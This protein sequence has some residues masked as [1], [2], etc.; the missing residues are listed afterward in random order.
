M[1]GL[2]QIIDEAKK[3]GHDVRIRDIAFALL[4]VGFKDSTIA[5][6]VVFGQ[7]GKDTDI[8]AYESLDSTRYLVR[9][10]EGELKPQVQEKSNADLIRELT[11]E[12]IKDESDDESLS[13]EENREGIE[14]QLRE[15]VELKKQAMELVD[16]NGVPKTD[17]KTLALLQ[18]TEADLRVKLNDKFGAAEKSS[19]QYVIV[20]KKFDFI[21]PHTNRECYQM[22]KEDAKK[23]WNLT[24]K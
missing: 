6:T 19:E 1:K 20:Q 5:Y 15:I 12:K 7:P 11:K 21:C 14:Q 9:L 16:E 24:E 10:Y 4:K 23:H 18:K 13:F 17:I 3:R 8:A 22:T 2:N